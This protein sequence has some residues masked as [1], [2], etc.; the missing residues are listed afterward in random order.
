[1]NKLDRLFISGTSFVLAVLLMAASANAQVFSFKWGALGNGEGQFSQPVGIAID[2]A[3]NVY[4]SDQNNNRVQKFTSD[5][6]FITQWGSGVTEVVQLSVPQGIGIDSANNVYVAD[7][8]NNRVLKYL[9]DGTFVTQWGST[10]SGSGQ[11]NNPHGIGIDRGVI[12]DFVYV[13]D[14]SNNRVQVFSTDGT[15]IIQW[16]S[17]GGGDGQFNNP[18]AI[19]VDF[20]HNIY[21]SDANNRIQKFDDSGGFL[22]SWG[23]GGTGDGQ[24]LDPMGIGIDSSGNLFVSEWGNN[25]VQEF[26]PSGAF[27][28]KWGIFGL[29]DGQFQWAYGVAV[30]PTGEIYVVDSEKNQVQVFTPPLPPASDGT[31][32]W[33]Y[34]WTNNRITNQVG[35]ICIPG[36]DQTGTATVTQTGQYIRFVTSEGDEFTGFVSGLDINASTISPNLEIGGFDSGE[37]LATFPSNT[38]GSGV[39]RYSWTDN[40]GSYCTGIADLSFT[41]QIPSSG[42][43]GGGGGCFIGAAFNG[44]NLGK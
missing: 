8:S 29:E 15:F 21:V 6:A 38:S 12:E 28:T 34:S 18:R 31:G 32:R 16:G 39:L 19:A 30:Q 1:M 35:V 14:F 26:D 9:S 4:I 20:L 25:R 33:V 10:G 3:G 42:G 22:S 36:S 24:F 5:G 23:T 40:I 17:T 7:S 2:G 11:F 37:I 27:V 41:K 13:T 44:W 43:G